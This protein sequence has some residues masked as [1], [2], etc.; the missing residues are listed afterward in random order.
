MR[1]K[2]R[3]AFLVLCITAAAGF[4]ALG[5]WQLQRLAWK[6]DLIARVDARVHAAPLAPPPR[7]DWATFDARANEYRRMRLE[8]RFLNDKATLVDALTE[9][10]P[11]AWVVTP[12][13]TDDGTVLVNR[14]FVPPDR[15]R[16]Y[17]RIAGVVTVV[18]LLRLSEP[19]GRWLR[20]NRP[21]EEA[22]YSRDVAAIAAARGL[23]DVAPYFVDA[24]AGAPASYPV[25]GLTVVQF[26]NMHLVY[27]VTWFVLAGLAGAGAWRVLRDG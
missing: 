16:D 21:R 8:G 11:G 5:V 9:R 4:S 7:S 13:V 15:R 22:W 25:G 26:R 6:R 17:E 10:G 19:G 14:G 2:K 23:R 3:A 1:G 20:P 24:E 12:L 27:A 18:G